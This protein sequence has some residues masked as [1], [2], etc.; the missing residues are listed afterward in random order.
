MSGLHATFYE[1]CDAMLAMA[2]R[3]EVDS[4]RPFSFTDWLDSYGSQAVIDFVRTL[5]FL[6]ELHASGI[7]IERLDSFRGIHD[8]LQR[9]FW[10]MGANGILELIKF[11]VEIRS[12]DPRKPI[13]PFNTQKARDAYQFGGPQTA[14]VLIKGFARWHTVIIADGQV[15][16]LFH[17][18]KPLPEGEIVASAGRFTRTCFPVGESYEEVARANE[19]RDHGLLLKTFAV[20]RARR[21]SREAFVHARLADRLPGPVTRLILRYD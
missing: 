1:N 13:F 12:L 6:K 10:A 9:D 7:S 8:Y 15:R 11:L 5:P 19:K 21:A 3:G 16:S 2:K 17:T 4:T 20:G 14:D 18:F